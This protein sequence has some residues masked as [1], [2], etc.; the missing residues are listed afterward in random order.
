[1]FLVSKTQP[2]SFITSRMLSKPYPPE[3]ASATLRFFMPLQECEI[4][5]S[6]LGVVPH[7]EKSYGESVPHTLGTD[8]LSICPLI[9]E[10]QDW[11]L[12]IPSDKVKIP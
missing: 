2:K 8:F 11:F 3:I 6:R 10:D 12:E 4:K 9:Q 7:A 1:M 5:F